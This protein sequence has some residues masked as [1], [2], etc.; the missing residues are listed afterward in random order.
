MGQSMRFGR[1]SFHKYNAKKV[2]CD[3][4][5]F[6][7]QLERDV[8]AL[9]KLMKAANEIA[10][11]QTQDH[12]YLT[13]ARVCLIPD[14]K[15]TLISGEYEWHEAKGFETPE[16]RIKRRLWQHYGPGLLHVWKRQG[17]SGVKLSEIIAVKI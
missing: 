1:A 7:S 3:G 2:E 10:E 4:Y 16:W 15:V 14:F 5:S 6:S 12:V 11:I 17:K 8:Y 13:N 9:L